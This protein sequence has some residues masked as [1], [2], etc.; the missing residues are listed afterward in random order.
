MF[1]LSEGV[2]FGSFRHFIGHA[3]HFQRLFIFEGVSEILHVADIETFDERL[4]L[5]D[6]FLEENHFHSL[7]FQRNDLPEGYFDRKRVGDSGGRDVSEI[8]QEA[9]VEN[10]TGEFIRRKH[11]RLYCEHY[12]LFVIKLRRYDD[13]HLLRFHCDPRFR[14]WGFVVFKEVEL[15]LER[16]KVAFEEVEHLAEVIV[17]ELDCEAIQLQLAI[18][19]FERPSNQLLVLVFEY[20]LIVDYDVFHAEVLRVLS[21]QTVDVLDGERKEVLTE[22]VEVDFDYVN[23]E[24]SLGD[25]FSETFLRGQ[26]GLLFEDQILDVFGETEEG[27]LLGELEVGKHQ[28]LILQKEVLLG[29]F[30]LLQFF[31]RGFALQSVDHQHQILDGKLSQNGIF[32]RKELLNGGDLTIDLNGLLERKERVLGLGDDLQLIQ[33]LDQQESLEPLLEPQEIG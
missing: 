5:I 10:E 15:R 4:Q 19:V 18:I 33:K 20:V 8:L 24:K 3:L 9:T 23:G 11:K 21:H 26:L 22:V 32:L 2:E 7:Q 25:H 1:R 14:L 16:S 30:E 17:I 27:F 13:L 12:L 29:L 28:E 6:H 31:L